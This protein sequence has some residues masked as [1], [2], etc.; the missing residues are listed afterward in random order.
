MDKNLLKTILNAIALAMGVA[1]IVMQTLGSLGTG[2]AITLLGV[3]MAALGIAALQ[4]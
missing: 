4:K 1:V 2:T 3:G